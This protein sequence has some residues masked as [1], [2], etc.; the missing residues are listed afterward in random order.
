MQIFLI[1]KN[2][3]KKDD[4]YRKYLPSIRLFQIVQNNPKNIIQYSTLN[5]NIIFWGVIFMNTAILK[6]VNDILSFTKILGAFGFVFIFALI[7]SICVKMIITIYKIFTSKDKTIFAIKQICASNNPFANLKYTPMPL[8]PKPQ[9]K[10]TELY[11]M[12]DWCYAHKFTEKRP[13]KDYTYDNVCKMVKQQNHMQLGILIFM[14]ASVIS[15]LFWI[16]VNN[17]GS[18]TLGSPFERTNYTATYKCTL[19]N[20]TNFY[21][22][23]ADIQ[24]YDK[25]YYILKIYVPETNIVF[26]TGYEDIDI[27]EQS[28]NMSVEFMKDCYIELLDKTPVTIYKSNYNSY[29]YYTDNGKCYHK[30]DCSTLQNSKLKNRIL[31]TKVGYKNLAPCSKCKP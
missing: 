11:D 17:Y 10:D 7:I 2:C 20:E 27:S 1:K 24:K 13:L 12:A 6:L 9:N 14:I 16:F 4:K 5:V 15:L 28:H 26:D 19:D 25:Y 23:Y 18:T 21:N 22:A 8:P 3:T 30:Y 31:K 29:V